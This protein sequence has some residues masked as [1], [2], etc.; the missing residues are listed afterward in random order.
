MSNGEMAE[1]VELIN[2][3]VEEST[4]NTI[5]GNT[6]NQQ[7]NR[8]YAQVED[9]IGLQKLYITPDAKETY[10]DIDKDMISAN[11]SESEVAWVKLREKYVGQIDYLTSKGLKLD[12]LKKHVK[13]SVYITLNVSLSRDGY[14]RDK[15][16]TVTT[17]FVKGEDQKRSSTIP[18]G[19]RR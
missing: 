13:R 15:L 2:D 19:F 3:S 5:F 18:M 16:G 11:L 9:S 10:H 7:L 14:L 12:N 8:G 17:R 4:T 6:V 1:E